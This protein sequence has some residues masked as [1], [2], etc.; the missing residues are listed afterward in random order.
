MDDNLV[1]AVVEFV[2]LAGAERVLLDVETSVVLSQRVHLVDE[3]VIGVIGTAGV[4]L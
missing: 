1:I 2:G 4:H 3:L